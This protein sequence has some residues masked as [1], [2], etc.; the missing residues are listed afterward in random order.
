MIDDSMTI[1]KAT[2]N[3]EI[4]MAGGELFDEGQ[5]EILT[6]GELVLICK[7]DDDALAYTLDMLANL[8][9][10]IEPMT[11]RETAQA[12]EIEELKAKLAAKS[13]IS[14]KTRKTR[15]KYSKDDES[16]IAGHWKREKAIGSKITR[17]E[18]GDLYNISG[19]S[20][21]K[22]LTT[23]GVEKKR[24]NSTKINAKLKE[25]ENA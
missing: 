25:P 14:G 17:Q 11:E 15:T 7:S 4:L 12:K 18:F 3:I 16:K 20:V 22:I 24:I 10:Y 8:I 21:T 13:T 9:E 6:F 2:D 1:R 5:D 19:N 23:F